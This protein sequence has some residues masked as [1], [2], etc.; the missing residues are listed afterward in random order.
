MYQVL[1]RIEKLELIDKLMEK[2]RNLR[3]YMEDAGEELAIEIVFAGS[4]V[5]YFQ[6]DYSAFIDPE[7]DIALC[8]NALNGQKMPELNDRNIRT[9]RA[10]IGEIIE[11]KAQGWIE[12]T[13]E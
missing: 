12:Y 6:G 3:R 11:K 1:F 7:L 9:V 8:R 13:I 4:V 2:V 10:G 5:R